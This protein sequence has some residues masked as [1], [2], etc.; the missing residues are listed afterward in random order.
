MAKQIQKLVKISEI[1]EEMCKLP[2]FD[3]NLPQA[4]SARPR[5]FSCLNLSGLVTKLDQSGNQQAENTE[6]ETLKMQRFS[7]NKLEFSKLNFIH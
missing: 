6:Y 5:I 7:N 4:V 3:Q 2:Q 1:V